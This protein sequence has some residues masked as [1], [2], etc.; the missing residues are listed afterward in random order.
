MRQIALRINQDDEGAIGDVQQFMIDENNIEF[1]EAF[2][3][4]YKIV[5]KLC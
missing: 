5:F 1:N 2:Y 4:H 3:P